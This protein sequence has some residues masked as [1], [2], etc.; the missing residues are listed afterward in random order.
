MARFVTSALVAIVF[1][2]A[3]CAYGGEA[4]ADP[5]NA[6]NAGNARKNGKAVVPDRVAVRFVTPET[7]G[8][9]KPRFI[10]DRQLAFFT[11]IETM[12]EGVTLPEGEYPDRYTRVATDR[13]VA[14]AMLASLLFQRGTEPLD[15]PR[16]ALEARAE[17]ADRIG[18]AAALDALLKKEG[19]EE[20]ELMTFLREKVRA[21]WYVDKAI[22][23]ISA[24][25]E[26]SLREAFRGALHP[27]RGMKY[28][29]VRPRLRRWVVTERLR[30]AELEFLQSARS[31]VNV[32]VVNPVGSTELEPMQPH[33]TLPPS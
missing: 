31:R 2:L 14:R 30:S 9:A 6:G 12:M 18:G 13:M 11:R 33:S 10:T 4:S 25:T 22:T 29:D 32:A 27:Y 24:V 15:L 23:P 28:E 17:L 20:E 26:D 8:M 19:L 21:T 1:V 5:A 7:G 3:T 16:L